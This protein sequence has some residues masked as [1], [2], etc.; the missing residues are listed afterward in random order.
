[1]IQEDQSNEQ[2]TSTLLSLQIKSCEIFE[3]SWP[4][5]S[6]LGPSL[7]GGFITKSTLNVVFNVTN[8][9]LSKLN[10]DCKLYV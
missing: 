2:D 4:S 3:V 10:I 5:E 8:F 9:I 1:M 7:L 6:M